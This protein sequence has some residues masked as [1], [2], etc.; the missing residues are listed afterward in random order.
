MSEIN[1]EEEGD[2]ILVSLPMTIQIIND[3][4]GL[5][6]L[7]EEGLPITVSVDDTHIEITSAAMEVESADINVSAEAAV[8]VEAGADFDLSVGGAV[9]VESSD[10]TIVAGAV[11]VE[12]GLFTVE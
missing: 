4:E 7:S 5:Q 2:T 10:I 9:E 12:S 6:I 8:E 1:T 3:P 11:E